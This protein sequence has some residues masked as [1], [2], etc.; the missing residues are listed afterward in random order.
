MEEENQNKEEKAV[1]VTISGRVQG[2]GFRMFTERNAQTKN[3]MGYVKNLDNG[4]VEAFFQGSK[5]NVNEMIEVVK[6]GPLGSSVDN[7]TVE[8]KEPQDYNSFKATA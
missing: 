1:K 6:N 3:V 8:E 5:E 2:V 7:I 4:D